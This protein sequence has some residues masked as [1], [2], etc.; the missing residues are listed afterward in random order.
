MPHTSRTFRIM[1]TALAAAGLPLTGLPAATAVDN[2]QGGGVPIYCLAPDG[3]IEAYNPVYED[4]VLASYDWFVSSF[5]PQGLDTPLPEYG[6]GYSV[7]PTVAGTIDQSFTL[8]LEALPEPGQTTEQS[9]TGDIPFVGQGFRA[10]DLHSDPHVYT[11]FVGPSRQ[12]IEDACDD[13]FYDS[14]GRE[15]PGIEM[16]WAPRYLQVPDGFVDTTLPG[17]NGGNGGG[18]SSLSS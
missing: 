11:L 8:N 1:M 5:T 4:G 6:P 18:G 2:G 3:A 14:T 12:T 9:N 17:G 13:I 7:H 16:Y 15:R 10:G